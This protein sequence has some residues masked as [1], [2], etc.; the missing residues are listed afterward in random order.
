MAG[1]GA[2]I[3]ATRF[4]SAVSG[5]LPGRLRLG[6]SALAL[7]A[8]LAALAVAA[9][10]ARADGAKIVGMR[11]V[12]GDGSGTAATGGGGG[13]GGGGNS[14]VA[15]ALARAASAGQP[16]ALF[17]GMRLNR[18][19]DA[20]ARNP[21]I[22]ATNK[23]M[24]IEQLKPK[25]IINWDRFNIAGGETVKFDQKGNR[26]WAVLNR[27]GQADPSRIDGALKADG[28]V[29][30]INQN[31]VI[32]GKGSRVNVRNL[33]ASSLNISTD[34]FTRGILADNSTDT[35]V[36]PVFTHEGDG[37]PGMIRVER[38]ALIEGPDN[39]SVMLLGGSVVNEGTI[40]AP[41]GQVVIGAGRNIYL[42]P[43]GSNITQPDER[44]PRGVTIEV[45]SLPG[46]DSGTANRVVNTGT[47]D[48][49]RGGNISIASLLIDQNGRLSATTTVRAGG[50]IQ[51]KAATDPGYENTPPTQVRRRASGK[52]TFGRGSETTIL[53]E[54]SAD[55]IT[56]AETFEHSK[57]QVIAGAAT[58]ERGA[59]IRAPAG[60]VG[61][62][63]T[64]STFD[65]SPNRFTMERGSR[66]DVSGTTSTEV[67]MERNQVSIT[68]R[69]N[70]LNSPLQRNGFLFGKTVNVDI[71][72]GSPIGSIDGYLKSVGR[73][74]AE[75]SAAGGTVSI[76]ST[77]VTRTGEVVIRDGA[78]IDVSGGQVRYRGG[79]LDT[80][81]LVGADGRVYDIGE[82]TPDIQ[83]VAFAEQRFG[84]QK[85][86]G[87]RWEAGYV[88]GMDAGSVSITTGAA[89]IDGSIAGR[90]TAGARQ[91]AR[92]QLPALGR[93]S[94][95]LTGPIDVTFGAGGTRLPNGFG[96]G[97]ALPE[98]LRDRLRLAPSLVGAT[99]VDSISVVTRGGDIEVPRGVVLR[100]AP[101]GSV[102]LQSHRLSPTLGDA[103]DY[104]DITVAG[105]IETPSGTI[106]LGGRDITL[107]S[108]ARLAARGQW[109]NDRIDAQGAPYS[110]GSGPAGAALPGGGS[111][112]L[113]AIE[114]PTIRHG[115]L[116]DV[117][118]G[119]WVATDGS[120]TKGNGGDVLLTS[121]R[122]VDPAYR[123]G[124]SGGKL[125]LA[126]DIRGYGLDR[127]G[128][129][130]IR[131]D[132][133]WI[134]GGMA[135]KGALVLAP[136][137]LSRGGFSD[138]TLQG[139]RGVT[140]APGAVVTPAAQTL[141]LNPD[142]LWRAG[143][144]DVFGFAGLE[145]LPEALR[146]AG[147]LTLIARASDPADTG[148]GSDHAGDGGSVVFGRGSVVRMGMG[149]SVTA[150][151]AR[152]VRVDGTIETPAGQITLTGGVT[153]DD[154]MAEYDPEAG[155]R[156]GATGRL[157]ARGAVRLDPTTDGTRRGTV[158][159]GG[160][161]TLASYNGAVIVER[162]ALLDVSGVSTEIDLRSMT[163]YGLKL[164]SQT[165][166]GNGGTIRLAGSE[167]L[168]VDGTLLGR[169][170]GPGAE[171]GTLITEV[172]AKPGRESSKRPGL[173]LEF[174]RVL[175][176]RQSG[177][178]A[179]AADGYSAGTL[180]RLAGQGFVAADTVMGG[181]FG[182]W[183][184]GSANV[185]NFDGDVT[186]K[187]GREIQISAYTI[188]ATPGSNVVL[189]APRVAFTNLGNEQDRLGSLNPISALG[190][191]MLSPA[192]QLSILADL[193]DIRGG[194]FR[195]GGLYR[196]DTG[197]L[198]PDFQPIYKDRRFGG[199][200]TAR[201]ESRGDIR[202]TGSDANLTGTLRSAGDLV[203]KA[204]QLYPASG[205]TFTIGA[206]GRV[207]VLP[208]G[209]ADAPW[210]VGGQLTIEAPEI[211]QN[212]TIRA[213]LGRIILGYD[214]PDL[215]TRVALGRGSVTSVSAD[216]LTVPYGYVQDGSNWLDPNGESISTPPVKEVRLRGDD[217]AVA[218]GATIDV[219]G[220]GEMLASEFVPGSGGPADVL[221]DPNS[222][223]VIPGYD[224]YAPWDQYLSGTRPGGVTTPDFRS[225]VPV[226]TD[227]ATTAGQYLQQGSKTGLRV[228]DRIYLSGGGGLPA[229]T[230]VLLPA[231]YALMP[232]AYRVRAFDGI[233]DML[234]A[235]NGRA[236]D[237]SAYV[238]GRRSVLNTGIR[239]ARWAGFHIESG[240]VLRQRAQ[241]DEYR[242]NSFFVSDAFRQRQQNDGGTIVPPT[243]PIDGGTLVANATETLRLDGTGL[244]APAEGGRL[245]RFDVAAAKVAVVSA[246]VDTQDLAD[247][248][249]LLLQ[250]GQINGFG[251][252]SLL[253]GGERS[254]AA[255]TTADPRGGTQVTVSASDVV[256]R[257]DGTPLQGAEIVLA[258]KN[259]VTVES[260]SVIRTTGADAGQGDTLRLGLPLP[261]GT[262]VPG[263][264][265]LL[266]LSTGDR[267]DVVRENLINTGGTLTVQEGAALLASG[268]LALDSSGDTILA[269]DRISGG[270]AIDAAARQISFGD[271]PKGTPGLV[272]RD[273]TLGVLAQTEALT[274][275][276]YGSIDFH[277]DVA[278]GGGQG[279]ALR[280]LSLDSP[281][282]I[283]HDGADVTINAG[284]V[285]LRNTGSAYEGD[286]ALAGGSLTINAATRLGADGKPVA[287]TGRID[288][289]DGPVRIA[290]F[291][292]V[293][294]AAQERIVGTSGLGTATDLANGGGTEDRP[295]RLRVDGA[296][297]LTAAALS[298]GAGSDNAVEAG[299]AL[300]FQGRAA[301][302]LPGFDEIGGR[303]RLSGGTVTLAGQ[304]EARAGI[305]EAAATGGDLVIAGGTVIDAS[306]VARSF[307]DQTRFAPGG[308]V[309]LSSTTGDVDLRA[310]S[311]IALGGARATIGG[312][313]Q[314]GDAG[315]LIV[316]A[317]KGRFLANGAIEAAAVDGSRQGTVGLD[318]RALDRSFDA[319]AGKLAAAGFAEAQRLRIRSGDVTIGTAIRAREFALAVDGG[320]LTIGGRIDAGG[321]TG[322]DIRLAA[323]G[324]LTLQGGA[325]LDASGAAADAAGKG[326]SV[327]LAA[328]DGGRIDLQSGSV[329]AVGAGGATGAVHLRA[330]RTDGDTDVAI[331]GIGSRIDGAR[332]V[333]VEAYK[334]F[335]V[336]E[337]NGVAVIDRGTPD[338][339]HVIDQ[340]EAD[341]RAFAAH[342]GAIA[343]RLGGGATVQAG[344]E[345]RSG[346][347]ML[348]PADTDI[349]D[350]DPATG[351]D[352]RGLSQ[353]GLVGVLT[354]RAGG[355]L[356]LLSNL[357][358]GFAIATDEFGNPIVDHLTG[359]TKYTPQRGES[360][361]YRLVAGADAT[362]ADPLAL[363]TDADLL[364][365]G[366]LTIG[367]TLNPGDLPESAIQ[368]H[369][370][371]GTGDI[372]I[373]AAEDFVLGPKWSSPRGSDFW[374]PVP[375]SAVYTAGHPIAFSPGGFTPPNAAAAF[376]TGGGDIT[377]TA[378]GS[379]YGVPAR[380]IVTEYVW[381]QT[382]P[383]QPM[384]WWIDVN[385]FQQGVGALGGGNVT[386][387]AGGDI[388]NLSAVIPTVG[389]VSS[390]QTEIRNG[391]SLRVEAL[392]DILSGVYYVGRGD[393]VIEAGGAI[394][395][396]TSTFDVYNP[397]STFPLH[398][399]LAAGDAQFNV[400][401]RGDLAI[402]TTLDPMLVL[403][404][405]EQICSMPYD[406]FSA[407]SIGFMSY[408][409]ES[410]VRLDSVGG[411]L[412]LSS[413]EETLAFLLDHAEIG[414]TPY[415]GPPP[416]TV[417][418]TVYPGT[419]RATT[420][421]GDI[422][423]GGTTLA[424]TDRGVLEL[425]AGQD[426][427]MAGGLTMA[428]AESGVE[429]TPTHPIDL[430]L[431]YGSNDAFKHQYFFDTI[432]GQTERRFGRHIGDRDPVRIY[433]AEGD[434]RTEPTFAGGSP[435]T[436]S[437]TLPK[438]L[439]MRAGGDIRDLAL[440]LTN[441]NVDDVTLIQ[442][443]GDIDFASPNGG[444]LETGSTGAGITLGGPG[445]LVV[446]AGG[447]IYL[448]TG[449]GIVTDGNLRSQALPD[450]GADITVLAG[451]GGNQQPD[452]AGFLTRYLDPAHY[453]ALE[454]YL[455]GDGGSI[456]TAQMIA[457]VEAL[458]GRTGLDAAAAFALFK[459]L[460][461]RQ[462]DPL[463]RDIFYAELRASGREANDPSSP[464]F[465]ATD[466]G[467]AAADLM[468][469]GDGYAG[470]I[471]MQD[472]QIKTARG[473]DISILVPGGG[474]QL[475]TN[476]P[477]GTPGLHPKEPSDSGLWTVLGGDIRVFA[478]DDIL[479]RASRAL[480][481]SGGDILMW[482]SFGDIDAGVGSRSA[483]ATAPAIVR[484]SL[485][486]TLRVE[487]GGV[488]SGSGIGALQPP[489]DV[490]LYAPNG[491]VDAGEGGIRVAGNFNVFALQVLNAD[492]I[493]VG[494]Q[495]VGLPSAPVNPASITGVSDVAAQATRAIEQS[496][497]DQAEK[498]AKPNDEPPPLLITG[499]FLGYEGG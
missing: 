120:L 152:M 86:Y 105:A 444:G 447:S 351:W 479:I 361:S 154:T 387:R 49:P 177:L 326:G 298:A 431:W 198:G 456:Y 65:G 281:A 18:I 366:T 101:G 283:G 271:A 124:K 42:Y 130:T 213:P 406:C 323:G 172:L 219:R 449:R 482:S 371:T 22:D 209:K 62:E 24:T 4:G 11:L 20:G 336:P 356:K 349:N 416:P 23:L 381:R 163:M 360:W 179:G 74:A 9:P 463:I 402:E 158:L 239:D 187:L 316:D 110:G 257:N 409:A 435:G 279:A 372:D 170:G 238:A 69:N 227:T 468:F 453:A 358:D 304:I 28:H 306:G 43:A 134:G 96:A 216:G 89:V 295:N 229:G 433:A 230:Y 249:Y 495:T 146:P 242:A 427:L 399:I 383:A 448:G 334:V 100:T 492:N 486:G 335:E 464:R 161:I 443:G 314:G 423:I 363:Q 397:F 94:L 116:I 143:G 201:F 273:G 21:V 8:G 45:D 287:G 15:G 248:G 424:A 325:V 97:D 118:A 241:Y 392:G 412:S 429:P 280:T 425:L 476:I 13:N 441:T 83:Y 254:P 121:G 480:T 289:A 208:N 191:R 73:T 365:G 247:Q 426:I 472:S 341:V 272:F 411:D 178:S 332:Q 308:V 333:T 328:G 439:E 418:L 240:E 215:D 168:F 106:T 494:G 184:M 452:R 330:P 466:R 376:P 139:Y 232:G 7:L 342:A 350:A 386:L 185:V 34:Q 305:L 440:A 58:M 129:L 53:P 268:S 99:G 233:L 109:V 493:Q 104:G 51:L 377:L 355:D 33:V 310:G 151:A 71:R 192:T 290:G 182:S 276:G 200:T 294:L 235:M 98:N 107:A 169:G 490:D 436:A 321:A 112:S 115:S 144:G 199:F 261:D 85:I 243:L 138:V 388:S 30:L 166:A 148:P 46:R 454:P 354:L 401:S 217:V 145:L 32:F 181:G 496:V 347:D 312:Q 437:I 186:V 14:I 16:R 331:T 417:L 450:R 102:D 245:G 353:D 195:L 246:G 111:I 78:V 10:P 113:G 5:I 460:A 131:T 317:A 419:L 125:I 68:L 56:D 132:R 497:R 141:R 410:S 269:T 76:G 262:F 203:F 338:D 252:G 59:E 478:Q 329:I 92:D 375:Q 470:G 322:G 364:A 396:G 234:P 451:L 489:G 220:G 136:D 256:V 52:I 260:G 160:T 473:G 382:D 194:D 79:W 127:G 133:I 340:V 64:E 462:Q 270:R 285:R 422:Q 352:L 87:P 430:T 126:G 255:V 251:V 398:T 171:G 135:P 75:R 446:S 214:D 421:S 153:L 93:L 222:F 368:V 122:Y 413:S 183:V 210:S 385:S 196:F 226:V 36:R 373:A 319:L 67:A 31:G 483:V 54:D 61:V 17:N 117:S 264:G 165:I 293:T 477:P 47:I 114:N 369:L 378:R 267:V 123:D 88:D 277:G 41:A 50:S 344:V 393:A 339:P 309:K 389:W 1:I 265:A 140:V 259:S 404:G 188:S 278:I 167:G 288:L 299:K 206:L 221:N 250:A 207:T 438:S 80:T 90:T 337:N 346:G 57:V 455:L 286:A 384:S 212:G 244:F 491:V 311:R 407:S 274:L 218:D 211:V 204:A 307:F 27:I 48:T 300:S 202:F 374:T 108:G 44:Y 156:I 301:P 66:I 55:T 400:R 359:E 231:R 157:L 348:L 345:L 459:G 40:R 434:V 461:P 91:R 84:Q 499:A 147:S 38:G 119:G 2:P 150:V 81:Q 225:D 77:A 26:D 95:N 29:Y 469:P 481:A 237:G 420:F 25:A 37:E 465:G 39:G 390:G 149:G 303:L 284:A 498:S 228:G 282:L 380:Q 159:D 432:A 266:R 395:S 236:P 174:L 442:A 176:I 3:P 475:G 180:D 320:N 189:Q 173:P 155:V 190:D 445:S 467:Y 428:D 197:K 484:L 162:G 457:T 474:I 205:Q 164:R 318:V 296:L 142:Y 362:G 405:P 253:I 414:Y 35:T 370:R 275:R 291:N 485:N 488:I 367:G 103:A 403:L 471:V 19:E 408:K 82:A 60:D 458:T 128:S 297:T 258:A 327:L 394:A 6:C 343:G 487:P 12:R 313:E 263:D 175:N 137:F 324:T 315:R 391:G 224:G 292:A 223:A 357:S 379:L 415:A 72:D 63:I 302:G 193:I 70:E